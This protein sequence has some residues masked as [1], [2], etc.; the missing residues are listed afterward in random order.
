[1]VLLQKD[2]KGRYLMTVPKRLV[3]KMEWVVGDDI[4]FLVL[5]TDAELRDGD[6]VVRNS[7]I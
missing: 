7:G 2:S 4:V 1:M 3:T 6:I 5:K